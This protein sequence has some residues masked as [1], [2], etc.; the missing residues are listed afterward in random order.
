MSPRVFL[1]I[2]TALLRAHKLE[3]GIIVGVQIKVCEMEHGGHFSYTHSVCTYFE[4]FIAA[5]FNIK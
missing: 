4:A 1:K 2:H 5:S 3:H